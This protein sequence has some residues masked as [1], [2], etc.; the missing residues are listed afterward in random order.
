MTGTA[1]PREGQ[2]YK[3][4][5]NRARGRSATLLRNERGL[6]SFDGRRRL[7]SLL[8]IGEGISIRVLKTNQDQDV[9]RVDIQE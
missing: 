1:N 9:V 6:D 8:L 4:S 3:D 2:P 5:V 7:I